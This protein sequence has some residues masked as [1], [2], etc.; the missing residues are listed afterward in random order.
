MVLA[1]AVTEHSPFAPVVQLPAF[2]SVALAPEPGAVKATVAPE[3]A[4]PPPSLTRTVNG[5]AKAV[6]TVAD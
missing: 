1:V 3:S 6:P 4:L 5:L 2:D